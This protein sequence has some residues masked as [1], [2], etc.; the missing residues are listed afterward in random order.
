LDLALQQAMTHSNVTV[1][2]EV[3]VQRFQD[4]ED[5]GV[6]ELQLRRSNG[7]VLKLTCNKLLLSIG[8]RTPTLIP[9]WDSFLH[10][11]RQIQGWIEVHP[12]S[13]TTLANSLYSSL[14]M[15]CFVYIS[16]DFPEAL[17][18]VPCDDETSDYSST[19]SSW[20]KVGIH[21]QEVTELFSW[22]KHSKDASPSEVVE[23]LQAIPLCLDPRSLCLNRP[24]S[25]RPVQLVATKPC[26]YTMTP[27]K[28][29]VIG[30]VSKNIFGV[31]GLSG[32]G[33]KMTPALG[34]MMADFALYDNDVISGRWNADFCSPNR[35]Y[36]E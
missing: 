20:L 35:F 21:K 27:D 12:N 24:S 19:T 7:S 28:H 33:F 6:V 13:D 22:A 31:A 36:C 17:Y 18:G 4:F 2:D 34:Q 3:H 30:S 10:P 25:N 32:H 26:V 23:L 5:Q 14:N 29:F 1:W 11:V 15:P 16:P 9:E 8:P